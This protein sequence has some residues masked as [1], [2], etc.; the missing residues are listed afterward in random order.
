MMKNFNVTTAEI[1]KTGK[2]SELCITTSLSHIKEIENF[3]IE[4]ADK[5]ISTTRLLYKKKK[6]TDS[7]FFLHLF[8]YQYLV[9]L[10][11]SEE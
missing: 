8:V 1:K 6:Y 11:D 10:P 9:P 4:E 7:M 2:F 5:A 3:W